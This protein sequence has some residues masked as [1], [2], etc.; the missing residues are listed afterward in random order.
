MKQALGMLAALSIGVSVL[1]LAGQFW[2][3]FDLFAHFRVQ[4]LAA[5]VLLVA[6]FL[7]RRDWRWSGALL[8]CA[9]VN[10]IPL[11]PYLWRSA[12]AAPDG[13]GITL[14][15][16]NVQARN[17]ASDQLLRIIAETRP[18]VLLLIEFTPRWGE[19]IVGL[20]ADYPHQ[21]RV[22]RAGNFGIALLSRY[23]FATARELQLGATAAIDAAL[24]MPGGTFRLVGVHLAPPV[25]AAGARERNAQLAALGELA[26]SRHQPLLITGDFNLSPYSP[27]FGE[28]LERTGLSDA[29]AGRGLDFTWPTFFPLLGIPIDHCLVSDEL[30]VAEYRRLG[31]FGSDHYPILVKLV[32]RQT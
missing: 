4:L 30:A 21:V 29:R 11:G 12:Q 8:V 23:P 20:N 18:D 19:H 24:K 14:L 32:R 27:H 15:T 22:P 26:E 7:L 10:A 6:A 13:A 17:E 25:S 1:A 3:V 2:W 28:L 31:R 16:V 5:Q 9:L